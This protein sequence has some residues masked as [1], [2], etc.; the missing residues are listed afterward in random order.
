MT[1][2]LR[3]SVGQNMSGQRSRALMFAATPL[4]VTG[5]ASGSITI[6]RSCIGLFALWGAGGAGQVAV[7]SGAGGGAACYAQVPLTAG[8]VVLY[9]S[10]AGGAGD[11]ADAVVTLPDGRVLRAGGGLAA[12]SGGQAAGGDVNRQGGDGGVSTTGRPG[13]GPGGGAGGVTG[14]ARGGGGGGGGLA[15][16]LLD[17]VGGDGGAGGTLVSGLAPG[18]GS[19]AHDTTITN[20]AAGRIIMSFIA[21]PQ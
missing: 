7:A 2:G 16:V 15:D 1:Q 21:T 11:G 3:G 5:A 12:G 4:Y 19:G 9:S 17:F 8:Q 18:G 20:G 6:R 10:P 13:Q 14:G